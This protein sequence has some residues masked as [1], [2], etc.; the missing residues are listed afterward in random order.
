M[1]KEA[2]RATEKCDHSDYYTRTLMGFT[3]HV[4][5]K[6]GYQWKA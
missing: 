4:C 5:R 1:N 3:F 2:E 6:C